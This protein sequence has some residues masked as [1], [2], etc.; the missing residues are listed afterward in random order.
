[1]K[2]ENVTF[3]KFIGLGYLQKGGKKGPKV[4]KFYTFQIHWAFSPP[5]MQIWEFADSVI[6]KFYANQ[7]CDGL[8][9]NL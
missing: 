8:G 7:I 4:D 2:F 6:F 1:M 3:C 5:R 9:P